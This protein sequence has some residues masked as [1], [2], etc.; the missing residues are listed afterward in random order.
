MFE[1]DFTAGQARKLWPNFDP[2]TSAIEPIADRPADTQGGNLLGRW[3]HTRPGGGSLQ[4][5]SFIDLAGR[6]ETLG[7]YRRR[8]I[9]VDTQYRTALGPRQDLVAGAGYRFIDES[10]LGHFGLSLTPSHDNATLLTAFVQDEIALVRDRVALTLGSQVQHNSDSGYGVQPSARVMW[11]ATPRQ[12][13]WAATSRALRTPALDERG[14]HIIY[15]PVPTAGGPPLVVAS[16]GNPASKTETFVDVEGG[17][18]LDVGTTVAIDLTGFAGRYNQL[19]TREVAAPVFQLV[20]FPQILV[21]SQGSNQLDAT[22]RG[23][24]IAGHWMPAAA[25]HFDGSYS[26]FHLSPH[27]A[28]TSTDPSAATADGNAP[29]RQWQVRSAYSPAARGMLTVALFHVGRLAQI[30]VDA[31]T[32]ADVTAEWRFNTRVS[33]MAIG[34]NLFDDM[35]A[36]FGGV[37]SLLLS[38]QVA[39]SGAVRL[40]WTF[41]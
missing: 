36:E 24:E 40:R 4:I 35:H 19:Q 9:D 10:F 14:F 18:R 33:V 31:Y 16:L 26:T 20:P 34:Q 15:A 7:D 25:W 5:Q 13:V 37:S 21:V 28:A 30:G 1:G 3:T 38:T 11:K 6:Q 39:R 23:V 22:T 8:V 32:R 29:G 27:L 2:R 12:R 41:R 17:Y